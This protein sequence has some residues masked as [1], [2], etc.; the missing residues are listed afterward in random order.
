[1]TDPA[2]LLAGCVACVAT[3]A[4]L[5]FSATTFPP[6]I[7]A[8]T[9]GAPVSVIEILG[10][11]MRGNPASLIVDAHVK[12]L[13]SGVRTNIGDVES[14]YIA[15][16]REIRDSQQLVKLVR[17]RG[18]AREVGAEMLIPLWLTPDELKWLISRCAWDG[19]A[20]ADGSSPCAAIRDQAEIAARRAQIAGP[21]PQIPRSPIPSGL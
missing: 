1:M 17:E 21:G 2:I 20:S 12:L 3:L 9:S 13:H 15:H 19:D 7:R 8:F 14:T 18:A 16:K 6:W 11:R 5:V 10:M 4:V